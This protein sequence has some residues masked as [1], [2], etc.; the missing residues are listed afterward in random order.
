MSI[1]QHSTHL[2]RAGTTITAPFILR[3]DEG[4]VLKALSRTA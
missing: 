2:D 3:G 4:V 1:R